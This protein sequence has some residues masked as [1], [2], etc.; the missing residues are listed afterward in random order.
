MNKKF[1]AL[2]AMLVLVAAGCNKLTVM[3]IENHSIGVELASTDTERELG[4]SNRDS[5]PQNQGMLFVFDHPAS[6][7]FWMK[8]MRFSLDLIWIRE[9]KVIEITQNVSPEPEKPTE[10]LTIYKP[11]NP[12]DSV[13]EVNA[14]WAAKNGIKVGDSTSL[15]K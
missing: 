15:T 11:A 10:L 13:L 12:A 3:K 5:M 7:G 2:C 4:L 9:G 14:G 6:Y 1:F 8:D